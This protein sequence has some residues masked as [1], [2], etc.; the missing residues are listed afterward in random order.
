MFG[1]AR[2]GETKPCPLC[3]G[4]GFMIR[5]RKGKRAKITCGVCKGTGRVPR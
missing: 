2:G 1:R 3:G 4:Q 5:I